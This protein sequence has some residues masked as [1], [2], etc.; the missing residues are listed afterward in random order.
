M[1]SKVSIRGN[2]LYLYVVRMN[3]RLPISMHAYLHADTSF[4]E[5]GKKTTVATSSL[6]VPH[7]S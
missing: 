6:G 3:F 2:N 1:N 5:L 7:T 4:L